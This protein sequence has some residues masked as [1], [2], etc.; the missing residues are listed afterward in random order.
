[1]IFSK[2]GCT[3]DSV[4]PK[5]DP[6][7]HCSILLHTLLLSSEPMN[8]AFRTSCSSKT[9]PKFFKGSFHTA[10]ASA[11]ANVVTGM[12][13]SSAHV[14]ANGSSFSSNSLYISTCGSAI[15][16]PKMASARGDPGCE[17]LQ[18]RIKG[19]SRK[20]KPSMEFEARWSPWGVNQTHQWWCMSWS[21]GSFPPRGRM[22]PLRSSEQRRCTGGPHQSQSH[23]SGYEGI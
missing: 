9:A 11:N 16:M 23:R 18:V 13:K 5:E 3:S 14:M 20:K 7:T 22:A 4:S 1:M 10:R 19:L 8:A 17:P 6:A 15:N 2:T 21:A 12:A